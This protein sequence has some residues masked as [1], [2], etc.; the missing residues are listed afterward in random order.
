M[1]PVR[2]R[3]TVKEGLD[4]DDDLFAHIDTPFERGRTHMRQHHHLLASEKLRIDSGL[5]LE[6][7]EPGPGQCAAFDLAFPRVFV[8]HLAARRVHDVGARFQEG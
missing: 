1:H 7:V 5:V 4:V 6:D 8:D 2:R 3:M